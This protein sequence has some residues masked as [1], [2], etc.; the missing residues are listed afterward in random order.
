MINNWVKKKLFIKTLAS[1]IVFLFISVSFQTVFAIENNPFLGNAQNENDCNC[2]IL[3]IA[4]YKIFNRLIQRL[5]VYTNKFSLLFKDNTNLVEKCKELSKNIGKLKTLNDYSS[6]CL[7]LWIY[8]K[9]IIYPR[10]LLLKELFGIA[11]MYPGFQ[12]IKIIVFDRVTMITLRMI[13]VI[14]LLRKYN[15]MSNQ[16]H[17]IKIV[18]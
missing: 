4:H 10:Y 13:S 8:Y 5:E 2:K 15:C 14:D 7:F 6:I 9:L 12:I 1:F 11:Y 3:S 17:S 18:I 16:F